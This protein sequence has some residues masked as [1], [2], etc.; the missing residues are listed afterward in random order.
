MR[1]CSNN[2]DRTAGAAATSVSTGKHDGTNDDAEPYGPTDAVHE[3]AD[4]GRAGA[5]TN[6]AA[7]TEDDTATADD[8]ADGTDA[9]HGTLAT[10]GLT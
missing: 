7:A 4:D 10:V 2:S 8:S 9:T 6:D 5:D 3:P 1:T